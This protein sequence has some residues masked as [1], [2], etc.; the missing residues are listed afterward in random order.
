MGYVLAFLQKLSGSVCRNYQVFA[1][2]SLCCQVCRGQRQP[3]NEGKQQPC[4]IAA[5]LKEWPE[6]SLGH[7][8]QSLT[9]T[10][11]STIFLR[12]SELEIGKGIAK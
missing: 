3:L 2:A 9:C 6:L 10:R 4:P 7:R 1:V 5:G 12:N 11:S 8:N